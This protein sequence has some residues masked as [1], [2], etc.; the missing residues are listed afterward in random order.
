[1]TAPDED[2]QRTQ[3]IRDDDATRPFST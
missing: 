3:V 2:N 1:V